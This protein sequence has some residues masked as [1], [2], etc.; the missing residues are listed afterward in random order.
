MFGFT[1]TPIF[2]ENAA[3]ASGKL[4]QT[5]EQTF[6]DRLHAYTI[7]DAIKDENVLPF[8]TAYHRTIRAK[9]DGKDAAVEGIDTEGAFLAPERIAMVASYILDNFNRLTGRDER[10]PA[11]RRRLAGFNA[12]LATASIDAAKRYY[13][14]F[15]VQ[16]VDRPDQERLRVATIFSYSPNEDL[17]DGILDDEEFDAAGLDGPSRDF[18][19][20]AIQDYNGVFGTSFDTSSDGFQGYHDDVTSRLRNRDLDLVIVVNMLLTGFDAT[21]LNTLFV[22]K[23]L[24]QH[25]LIQAYS[26]TN[27]ILDSTKHHGNIV[28]FRNLD[29]ATEDALSLFGDK[30]AASVV[31]IEPYSKYFDDYSHAIQELRAKFPVAEEIIGEQNQAAFVSL[32]GLVLRLRSVLTSFDEFEGNDPLSEADEQDYRSEYVDLYERRR[33]RDTEAKA[34]ILEDVVFEMELIKRVEANVDYVVMLVEE[35]RKAQAAGD[36]NAAEILR[37]KLNA[38]LDSSPSLYPKKELIAN[39]LAEPLHRDLSD[40][41]GE[42]QTIELNLIIAEE[43]LDEVKTRLLIKSAFRDGDL[44]NAGPAIAA[45]LPPVSRFTSAGADH[46]VR[47]EIV[48]ERLNEFFERFYGLSESANNGC[49]L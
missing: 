39:W 26:R 33:R 31:L 43:Q 17:P 42:Q 41:I 21:T 25:G 7:V 5:T 4:P 12:M 27:R 11:A 44:P 19:E 36:N 22:D 29:K 23:N 2:A 35:R 15:A 46:A 37:K 6:G 9:V 28:T 30:D 49:D 47:R 1:G 14:E 16:Q 18:L 34:S 45:V 8:R 32:F 24:R 48:I 13:A 38:T 3:K 40:F 20:D 10:L